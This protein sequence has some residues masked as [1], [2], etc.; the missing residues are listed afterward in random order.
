MKTRLKHNKILAFILSFVLLFSFS[1][2]IPAQGANTKTIKV[3]YYENEV[4]QEGAAQGAVK[5]GYAYEYY[6]KLSEYTG[7]NYEYV[8]G[9]FSDLYDMLLSGEIDLLAGLA[10]RDDRL[11]IIGYPESPM[12]NETY[13]L[14]KHEDDSSITL[15]PSSVS[16]KK[17]G[18]LESAVSKVLE[19]YLASHE[20]SAD[21]VTF[22]DY[23]SL[24]QAFDNN[25]VDILAAE[26]D[27]A[28][29]RDHAEVIFSFGSSDY[30]LCVSKT[31]PDLLDE[32]NTAQSL[33]ATEEPGY[34]N[35]LRNKYYSSSVS[36]HTYSAA[37]RTWREEH[38]SLHVGYLNNYLPY[39]AT[40]KDGNA[41]GIVSEI[42]PAIC[43]ELSMS[44]VSVS[45]TG[46]DN[47]DEMIEAIRSEKID[48]AFPVGGGL[49]Y[50]EENGIYQSAAVA[51]T[52]T[53]LVYKGE[54]GEDDALHFAV[55]E[56]N[57]MQ[58]YYIKT[59]FPD[60]EISFYP[61]I[62]ACL[63]AVLA[64][65]IK[66][67]TL[68]GLRANEI[69]KNRRYKGLYLKQLTKS[70]DRCFGVK[71][72]NEGLLK[73]LNRGIN[74]LGPEYAQD[75]STLYAEQLY[76]Y[77]FL[78]MIKDNIWLFLALLLFIAV[79]IIVMVSRD[80]K[81]T[82]IS[83]RLKSDFVSNMSHEIRT[84]VNAIL[85]MN[86]MIQRESDDETILSYS[87]N[88]ERA[89]GSL[90]GI[91]NDILD[92]SKIEAGRMELD[93]APYSLPELLSDLDLMINMRAHE[94]S[95]SFSM[96]IDE[97]L[98]VMPVG[99]IQKLRQV[100]TNLLTNAVKYTE[101]GS[102]LL[103][104]KLLSGGMND[105]GTGNS[106]LT[107]EFTMEVSVKDTGIGIRPEE[108]GK[109][110][111][112]FD[113]LDFEKT[114]NI[115][116]SGL[117]LTITQKLLS[118]MGSDIHVESEYGKGS[119]FFF[120]LRQGIS[121]STPIGPFEPANLS[122][123]NKRHKRRSASFTAPEAS[124][125][126]VDDT[127]MNLSVICGLLKGNLLQI[128]TA[129]NGNECIECF[130]DNS[131]DVVFLDYRMP[132]MDGIETLHKLKELYPSKTASTPVISLTANAFS[133]AK[134]QMINAG[135]TD[136]LP[137]PVNLSDME[138]MLLRYLPEEKVHMIKGTEAPDNNTS[139]NNT[140][141][142][143]VSA[144]DTSTL[145]MLEKIPQLDI[146]S[147]LD[148]CGDEEDYIDALHIFCSSYEE[149][150][151]SI[152][153][154]FDEHDHEALS[155]LAH[156]IKSTARAIGADEL[157]KQA[158]DIEANAKSDA[159]KDLEQNVPAFLKSYG[160]LVRQLNRALGDTHNS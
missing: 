46:Y 28:Y 149:K 22:D 43:S 118:L 135:F 151:A 82:R 79:L 57:R 142:D 115:E 8:Y 113:R 150:S 35:T 27:G 86:E 148:Y 65:D 55:N 2:I 32:L 41:T 14:V 18:V 139:D 13:S 128:D 101:K 91:I 51:S 60:A 140:S 5:T 159:L 61:N 133:A 120:E 97:R 42:I 147:G 154:K 34:I 146:E 71:I 130:K 53:D 100:I 90:L 54:Y 153:S 132:G 85:G 70:D 36:G 80:L 145:C 99:D 121:V 4:F 125:L 30:Y 93:N 138:A 52:T 131:Y 87:D 107:K 11:D 72:G 56:N 20:I 49:Y 33:L 136:Y 38:K 144:K 108:M 66:A 16:G 114:R 74:I 10:K 69:M 63:E 3:G 9:S 89:G 103:S 122:T 102:V 17:I 157:S 95:L 77:S 58:Y 75:V 112:A 127:P 83:A 37:E 141:D 48:I 105:K 84:P 117:G 81:R 76:S 21:V 68:N 67:T 158:A 134:E 152:L 126:V 137:K 160:S 62:D 96:D 104:V 31:R 111:T 156:S 155:L 24:F 39:S 129:I 78:D 124:L 88:I 19:E 25:T 109:L 119:R 23:E 26:G 1:Y 44:D 94:K 47:Y 106:D 50:S 123:E 6:R 98:P 29:G 110:Y 59:H 12:G 40:D 73:L 45:Y 143:N 64:G 116:G 7:W 92:F 15:S